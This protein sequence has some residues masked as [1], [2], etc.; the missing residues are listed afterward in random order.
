MGNSSE[1]G[2][3]APRR[4]AEEAPAASDRR[5]GPCTR[6]HGRGG[7][8]ASTSRGGGSRVPEPSRVGPG[9]SCSVV[10]R[11]RPG[12]RICSPQ[13]RPRPTPAHARSRRVLHGQPPD[14]T[15]RREASAAALLPAG[16]RDARQGARRAR[17][18]NQ[19]LRGT[20][21]IPRLVG[22]TP[23][24]D[25]AG[26]RVAHCSRGGSGRV[27]GRRK[28]AV[29]WTGSRRFRDPANPGQSLAAW[30]ALER[31]LR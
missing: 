20:A 17:D 24:T 14:D 5:P 12:S 2:Q 22:R 26:A 31:H 16:G 15:D 3:Q 30:G 18:R 7:V 1:R 4:P 10:L 21:G 23:A 29:A 13:P 27:S 8:G 6:P 25:A 28:L 19:I 11:V 9:G